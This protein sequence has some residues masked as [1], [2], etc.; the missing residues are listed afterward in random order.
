LPNLEDLINQPPFTCYA[1]YID[2]RNIDCPEVWA[3]LP[4]LDLPKGARHAAAQSQKGHAFSKHPYP[5]VISP[6]LT[7]QEHFQAAMTFAAEEHF[8][9]DCSEVV[10]TD[11]QFAADFMARE[12]HRLREARQW[13]I[14]AVQ[15]LARRLAGF[16][17]HL[18]KF[19]PFP[20]S[21]VAADIHIAF[22]AVAILLIAWPDWQFPMQFVTGM[23]AIGN[24]A[25]T[26]VFRQR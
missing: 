10:D 19:Q 9:L 16:S 13:R 8:P 23:M 22:L 5:Q 12:Y 3:P 20:V 18:R 25:R 24:L 11:T 6:G 7:Q 1:E 17:D 14:G 2:K 21:T 4:Y 26:G 15:E